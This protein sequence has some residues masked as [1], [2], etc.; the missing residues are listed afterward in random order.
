MPAAI[1]SR[2]Q[3]IITAMSMPDELLSSSA[4]VST[5]V[6]CW[7]ERM[8]GA[9]TP[10]TQAGLAAMTASSAAANEVAVMASAEATTAVNVTE[11]VAGSI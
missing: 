1:T 10:A 5:T 8:V 6:A 11:E 2:T 4:A 7:I 3:T 9:V